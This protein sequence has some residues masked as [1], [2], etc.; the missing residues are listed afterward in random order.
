[1]LQ[2][3]DI[4]FAFASHEGL[5]IVLYCRELQNNYLTNGSDS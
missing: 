5:C 1:M 2:T 3:V 4:C